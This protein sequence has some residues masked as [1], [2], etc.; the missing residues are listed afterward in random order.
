MP[1]KDHP[2]QGNDTIYELPNDEAIGI[3]ST[4]ATLNN[5]D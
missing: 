5:D 4:I 3:N 2:V 1:Q